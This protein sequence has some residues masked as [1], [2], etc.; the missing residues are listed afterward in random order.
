M[1]IGILRADDVRPELAEKHG[2]YPAM[3]A[4]LMQAAQQQPRSTQFTN[5]DTPLA[6]PAPLAPAAPIAPPAPIV[7]PAPIA[8]VAMLTAGSLTVA[9]RLRHIWLN[10]D[11]VLAT[12]GWPAESAA[13]VRKTFKRSFSNAC[14]ILYNIIAKSSVERCNNAL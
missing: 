10:H 11:A 4:Q 7:P 6:P 12:V 1:N 14:S 9:A 3:I 5:L 2:E 13:G 8:P